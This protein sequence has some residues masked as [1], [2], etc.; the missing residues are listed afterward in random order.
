MSDAPMKSSVPDRHLRAALRHAPGHD[1]APPTAL[2]QR[3]IATAHTAL[4]PLPWWRHVQL[5]LG[6]LMQR[7]PAAALASVA[8]AT[9]IGL[10]WRGDV[11]PEATPGAPAEHAPAQ[12]TPE[13]REL[14]K[15]PVA[16]EATA[17]SA[18]MP[19]S[20][21]TPP[22]ARTTPTAPAIAPTQPSHRPA[23]PPPAQA[24]AAQPPG[25][26]DEP[27]PPASPTPTLMTER[28]EA[29]ATATAATTLGSAAAPSPA[30]RSDTTPMLAR[31]AAAPAPA[32]SPLTPLLNSLNPADA[33]HAAL[34]DLQQAGLGHWQRSDAAMAGDAPGIIDFSDAK[35]RAL[36]RLRLDERTAWWFAADGSTWRAELPAQTLNALRARLGKGG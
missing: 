35:G 26:S 22:R 1:A 30:A 28:S 36:G 18:A 3:I 19:S 15:A 23:P 24:A 8:M 25:A 11:P 6:R 10:M 5:G 4:R 32:F 27:P 31:R 20:R 2:D 33:R 12:L 34:Q 29:K 9:T 21:P 14:A 17:T 13:V 7:V 16:A